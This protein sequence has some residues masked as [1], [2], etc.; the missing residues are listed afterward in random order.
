[1]AGAIPTGTGSRRGSTP[2]SSSSDVT[3]GEIASLT[4]TSARAASRHA[5]RIRV[6][7]AASFTSLPLNGN[8]D[9]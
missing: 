2:R 5:T 9:R 8:G 4:A 1:M 3:P 6:I 7:I